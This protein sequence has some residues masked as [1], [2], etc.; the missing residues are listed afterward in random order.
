MQLCGQ[1][2][3]SI[4]PPCPSAE[5]L[6]TSKCRQGVQNEVPVYSSR[7]LSSFD[8]YGE[9]T[10]YTCNSQSRVGATEGQP[11]RRHS[12]KLVLGPSCATCVSDILEM[13]AA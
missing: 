7:T 2:A 13:Q 6:N 10:W 4:P 12:R 1:E 5:G 11:V 3:T 8:V 9:M